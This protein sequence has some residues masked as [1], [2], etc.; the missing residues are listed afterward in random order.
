[1]VLFNMGEEIISVSD[2]LVLYIPLQK[3]LTL[4]SR[5]YT[6]EWSVNQSDFLEEGILDTAKLLK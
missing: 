2:I 1:M 4:F 6:F 3:F 5:E